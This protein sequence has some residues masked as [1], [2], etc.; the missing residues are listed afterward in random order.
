MINQFI[1]TTL[2]ATP[3]VAMALLLGTASVVWA[4]EQPSA[5]DA[6]QTV[7]V[8]RKADPGLSKQIN[9]SPGYAVFPRVDKGAFILGGAGGKGVL[10][11]KGVATGEVTMTQ[12]TVGAQIGGWI[13][14]RKPCS[15][16]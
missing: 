14:M 10:F 8:F 9:E 5:T 4:A 15:E 16:A 11:E 6:Q 12:I 7:D 3:R 2:A 1:K 13:W